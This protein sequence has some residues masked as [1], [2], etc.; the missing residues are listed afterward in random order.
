[1]IGFDE[2][3]EITSEDLEKRLVVSNDSG[4]VVASKNGTK[5]YFA[6][7]SGVGRINEENKIY[8]NTEEEAI[9][10]GYSLAKNCE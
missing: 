2:N 10:L 6:W 4:L 8:F 7:C 5:Y 1:M 3:I 9:I